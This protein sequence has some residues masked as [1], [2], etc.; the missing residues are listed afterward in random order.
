MKTIAA[1]TNKSPN[2]SLH[3]E[4]QKSQETKICRYKRDYIPRVVGV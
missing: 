4:K 3:N 2:L 1:A